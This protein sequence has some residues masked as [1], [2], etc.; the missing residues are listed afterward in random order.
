M[1][2]V[3]SSARYLVRFDDICPTMSWSVWEEIEAALIAS[4]VRPLL[5]VVPANEDRTLMVAP[6]ADD[7]W[8]RV[9]GWQARGWAIG[10]TIA[11]AFD[12]SYQATH[13][14]TARWL[15]EAS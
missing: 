6:P 2:P 3:A 1:T 5:A 8:A 4:E 13:I 15:L 14:E 7:F 12:S 11:W 10:Q 9:R